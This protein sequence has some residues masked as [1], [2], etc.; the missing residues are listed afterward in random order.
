M[1]FF[2]LHRIKFGTSDDSVIIKNTA[3]NM[4]DQRN[5]TQ[6][7]QSAFR[8]DTDRL[9]IQIEMLQWALAQYVD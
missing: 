2:S 8:S 5:K 9:W 3:N 7:G 1:I 6:N 4:L